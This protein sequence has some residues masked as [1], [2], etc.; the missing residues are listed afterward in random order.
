MEISYVEEPLV[1]KIEVNGHEILSWK[2]AGLS[3]RNKNIGVF[4]ATNTGKTTILAS[5]LY[6][7]KFPIVIL[8]TGDPAENSDLGKYLPNG[9]IVD[10]D[11]VPD[12]Y[13]QLLCRLQTARINRYKDVVESQTF[14]DLINA[15]RAKSSEIQEEFQT[16]VNTF[17]KESTN[18]KKRIKGI[19]AH[20][21][22][23]NRL[24]DQFNKEVEKMNLRHASDYY[25][26]NPHD[27]IFQQLSKIMQLILL[28][29]FQRPEIALVFDDFG[30]RITKN[31]DVNYLVTISRKRNITVFFLAQIPRLLSADVRD[32]ISIVISTNMGAYQW[33][34]QHLL[35]TLLDKK[36][37]N[38]C[39]QKI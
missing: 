10:F 17:T 21:D 18:I 4:G 13:F 14:C 33:V 31:A 25:T 20:A 28:G 6:T 30:D 15:V 2:S 7:I 3:F 9:L 27:P 24:D 32:N 29:K 11:R 35:K 39:R 38:I 23:Q 5:L 1:D 16:L 36:R 19:I 26:K 34:C 12:G 37:T 22:A 8:V